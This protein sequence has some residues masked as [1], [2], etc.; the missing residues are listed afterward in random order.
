MTEVGESNGDVIG[1][2]RILF[3][4]DER[5]LLLAIQRQLRTEFNVLL[6]TGY[7]EAIRML[8]TA[9]P[10]AIAVCDMRM[11][12]KDGVETLETIEKLS[13]DTVRIMLTG[14]ADQ[15]TAAAAINHGHIF[16]FLVKPCADD[17]LRSTLNDAL[18]QY[19]L[20]TAEKS[21]LQQTLTGSVRLM[22]EILS[23]AVPAAFGQ[24]SRASRWVRPIAKEL[25]LTKHWDIELATML[26]PIGYVAIPPNVAAKAARKEALSHTEREM[27]ARVPETG[28]NLLAHI[29]RLK[30]VAEWVYLHRRATTPETPVGAQIVK[31]LTDLSSITDEDVPTLAALRQL[32]ARRGEYGPGVLAAAFRLWARAGAAANPQPSNEVK[33]KSLILNLRPGDLLLES[34]VF[35]SGKLLLSAGARLSALQLERLRNLRALE[36][37]VEPIEVLRPTIPVG[38]ADVLVRS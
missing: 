23:L 8:E 27:L 16:R 15:S 29:P 36:E 34:I 5:N 38:S 22:V 18:H 35:K 9:G 14:N 32:Q 4:D 17:V 2:E 12:G 37:I 20:V 7:D 21:L 30:T 31:L 28:R 26:T 33:A 10:V 19:R 11:P 24:A 1:A 13:P 25:S 6:A 3:V